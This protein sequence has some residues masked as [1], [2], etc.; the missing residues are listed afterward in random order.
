[1]ICLQPDVRFRI[2]ILCTLYEKRLENSAAMA[3]KKKLHAPQP[4]AKIKINFKEPLKTGYLQK[5]GKTNT[6]FKNRFFVLYKHFLVYYSD[7]TKWKRDCT[8]ERLEVRLCSD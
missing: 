1:M 4:Q 3:S 6:A 8:V 5:A 7:E 2:N